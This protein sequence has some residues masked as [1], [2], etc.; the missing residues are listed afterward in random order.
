VRAPSSAAVSSLHEEVLVL[1]RLIAD[2]HLIA[3]GDTG[4]LPCTFE[5]GALGPV[6]DMA[7]RRF[8]PQADAKGLELS[9]TPSGLGDFQISTDE[10]RLA[11]VLAIVFSNSI[12]YT[13]APGSIHVTT[14]RV[15][16]D[17]E[18]KV[19]DSAPGV[20]DEALEVMFESFRRLDPSRNKESGGSGLGL[21]VARTLVG[22]LGGT[23]AASHAKAGGICVTITLPA[24]SQKS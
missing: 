1:T 18:I 2:L 17:I 11:Q 8:R 15:Q 22:A 21:A 12:R 23:I 16:A 4:R 24:S 9:F 3:L 7:C 10:H 19:E 14:A 13:A 6:V 5:T 20:D